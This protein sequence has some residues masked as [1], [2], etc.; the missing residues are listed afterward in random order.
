MTTTECTYSPFDL[1]KYLEYQMQVWCVSRPISILMLCQCPVVILNDI[2]VGLT[3]GHHFGHVGLY[4]V[5]YSLNPETPSPC[6]CNIAPLS[7]T[8]A[9]H[10]TNICSV[11]LDTRVGLLDRYP[12]IGWPMKA[13]CLAKPN[14]SNC[15]G[16]SLL[17]ALQSRVITT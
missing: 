17:L 6:C 13:Y 5:H 3:S 15:L 10:W 9:Q 12:Q 11:Y 2:L 14:V 7:T 4:C 16:E 8:L 1:W